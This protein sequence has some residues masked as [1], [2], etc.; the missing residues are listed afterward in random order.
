L[1]GK[2]SASGAGVGAES[3]QVCEREFTVRAEL[4]LHARPAG[5][6]AQLAGRY[7]SEVTLSRGG[8][9]VNGRSVLSILSL[10]AAAG[11]VLTVRA[12]GADAEQAVVAL[13]KL[14]EFDAAAGETTD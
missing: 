4:G 8:E 10:A 11:T 5:S 1:S 12:V 13:G 7:Q 6:L 14:L 2:D 9:W 3:E